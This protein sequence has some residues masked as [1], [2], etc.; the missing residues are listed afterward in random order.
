MAD[1]SLGK[2][3]FPAT[4][5]GPGTE[6]HRDGQGR[7]DAMSRCELCELTTECINGVNFWM[8]IS[9]RLNMVCYFLSINSSL[10]FE[11]DH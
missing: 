9:S 3:A 5:T 2:V 4:A 11:G 10:L 7:A 1:V 8:G 6:G